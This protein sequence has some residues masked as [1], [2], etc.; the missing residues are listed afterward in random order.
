MPNVYYV[1]TSEKCG[2]DFSQA[3]DDEMLNPEDREDGDKARRD[4]QSYLTAQSQRPGG[5]ARFELY[6][7]WADEHKR[8]PESRFV[9]LVSEIHDRPDWF[10]EGAMVTLRL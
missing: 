9:G 2:C 6:S 8:P 5:S 4:L 3:P 7:R 1:G 10:E